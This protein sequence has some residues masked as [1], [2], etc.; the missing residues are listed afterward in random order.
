MQE[1]HGL[2]PETPL[3][4][5]DEAVLDRFRHRL[6]SRKAPS[7]SNEVE[8]QG[9][10]ALL[11]GGGKRRGKQVA[12]SGEDGRD[13]DDDELDEQEEEDVDEVEEAPF[14]SYLGPCGVRNAGA[15]GGNWNQY[16]CLLFYSRALFFF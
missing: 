16:K 4:L 5:P 6:V 14:V 9:E 11:L 1:S 10:R 3:L 13:F 12:T 2:D 8:G 7:R 15:F